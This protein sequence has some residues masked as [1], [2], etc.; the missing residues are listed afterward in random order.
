[1]DEN[2]LFCSPMCPLSKYSHGTR[3]PSKIRGCRKPGTFPGTMRRVGNTNLLSLGDPTSHAHRGDESRDRL[4]IPTLV[5]ACV[6]CEL[7]HDAL[8]FHDHVT[9][10]LSTGGVGALP[11]IASLSAD[12]EASMARSLAAV[13]DKLSKAL[14]LLPSASRSSGLCGAFACSAS[15]LWE[16]RL[17]T[18]RVQVPPPCASRV[19]VPPSWDSFNIK[20]LKELLRV[21]AD[22]PAES[23][24][25]DTP[26]TVRLPRHQGE[27]LRHPRL[28]H[29]LS[30]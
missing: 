29:S 13:A 2:K 19:C 4:E 27:W 30:R 16:P 8:L 7:Y 14:S 17:W 25:S 1:M 6:S 22:T 5:D 9:V 18:L 11:F 26:G 10:L 12:V 3:T 15:P 24:L 20:Q 21:A 23:P 28:K